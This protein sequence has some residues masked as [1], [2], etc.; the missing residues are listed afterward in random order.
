MVRIGDTL[1]THYD[2]HKYE[3]GTYTLEKPLGGGR[4][5]QVFR[6]KQI[7]PADK[8][9]RTLAIK[10]AAAPEQNDRVESERRVLEAVAGQPG[11]PRVEGHGLTQ[12]GRV[13][14]V[15]ELLPRDRELV[16]LARS[17]PEGRLDER[18]G[19]EAAMQYA[20]MLSALHAAGFVSA[21]RKLEDI[22]WDDESE[23]G[24]PRLVVLDWNVTAVD[25][26]AGRQR[27][28]YQF[29]LFWHQ[30]LLGTP[31]TSPQ[32]RAVVALEQHPHWDGLTYG[33]QRF[34]ARTLSE[35]PAQ[36]YL[37]AGEVE[38]DLRPLASLL[39]LDAESLVSRAREAE[40]GGDSTTAFLAL[41]VIRCHYAHVWSDV[42]DMEPR[43]GEAVQKRHENVLAEGLRDLRARQ[44]DR[45]R[46][47]FERALRDVLKNPGEAVRVRRW[48]SLAEFGVALGAT[49]EA[50]AVFRE[51]AL[52]TLAGGEGK[53]GVVEDLE[54][55]QW[56]R[57][58]ERFWGL[59]VDG[60]LGAGGRGRV[61]S[62]FLEKV[63]EARRRHGE[64]DDPR[65]WL[66][67]AHTH[68]REPFP[69]EA[70]LFA[71]LADVD[72]AGTRKGLLFLADEAVARK[73]LWG[74]QRERATGDLLQAAHIY[75]QADRLLGAV[76]YA[77]QLFEAGVEKPAEGQELCERLASTLGEAERC[78]EAGRGL[79]QADPPEPERAL[80][81]FERGLS[82]LPAD[83]AEPKWA[84]LR[85]E[86]MVGALRGERARA[87]AYHDLKEVLE[88]DDVEAAL[89]R[90]DALLGQFPGDQWG[91]QQRGVL[92]ARL[93][94]QIE[95][96]LRA[97]TLSPGRAVSEVR[98]AVS[99]A[100]LVV[101]A[102]CYFEDDPDVQRRLPMWEQG[103]ALALQGEMNAL[104]ARAED[105]LRQGWQVGLR[106]VLADWVVA[107]SLLEQA[108]HFPEV[109]G[110]DEGDGTLR[111][112][113]RKLDALYNH[114]RH[115]AWL[116]CD[117][118]AQLGKQR[119]AQ[120]EGEVQRR[121]VRQRA[122]EL[123]Q[124]AQAVYRED[125]RPDRREA[126]LAQAKEV[127]TL[128]PER[129]DVQYFVARVSEEIADARARVLEGLEEAKSALSAGRYD[130][131]LAVLDEK[132]SPEA[133]LPLEHRED[134]DRLIARA[135][136]SQPL[137][138]RLRQLVEPGRPGSPAL[139]WPRPRFAE[140]E[141]HL[142]QVDEIVE[143]L[144]GALPGSLKRV[145]EEH[146]DQ[147]ES[148]LWQARAKLHFW[149][150][151]ALAQAG[152]ILAMVGLLR[153]RVGVSA[154]AGIEN[155]EVV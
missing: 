134:R 111:A 46:A 148:R 9:G 93:R 71:A 43:V 129:R 92:R 109:F 146:L 5:T 25:Q 115:L 65:P 133:D 83:I 121:R 74:V 128:W 26:E 69:R 72:A 28:L 90:C 117:M 54:E 48:L 143:E 102:G 154:V 141:K 27:D 64:G 8:A 44:Y 60:F 113:Q 75:D 38:D 87:E 32:D 110:E 108:A 131:A 10:I 33:T 155:Q 114:V 3:S 89:G 120:D 57:S 45:A 37:S 20:Q 77:G 67:E 7:T 12:D 30:L 35:V 39:A 22:I 51:R 125:G 142:R 34:L 1:T 29:G 42:A 96:S 66:R 104:I 76:P 86:G 16:R 145:L 6:G 105:R 119:A 130:E 84:Q 118:A 94:A 56:D 137:A 153:E 101:L 138:E 79:L 147:L 151:R 21:D 95:G 61:P 13:F 144:Q 140:A 78:L 122:E 135:E 68:L 18:T 88:A 24:R 139:M 63:E 50:E 11:F 19:V 58:T 98:G 107:H 127:L 23:P 41:S 132:V 106:E 73:K 36:R 40:V 14:L 149:N 55:G 136:R 85:G 91:I 2:E 150:V 152:W 100:Q 81:E 62:S 97:R 59:V 116:Q 82:L 53:P 4:I 49:P 80:Q 112:Q 126:A 17:D 47:R 99:I 52:A 31:A 103:A 124:A 123:W 70:G 15:M